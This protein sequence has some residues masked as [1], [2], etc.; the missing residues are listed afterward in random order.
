MTKSTDPDRR[1][2]GSSYEDELAQ[3]FPAV[4]READ[5]L[6]EGRGRLQKTYDRLASRLDQAGI[7]YSLVGGYALI[8]HGV[9][10]FT[11]DIDLLVR[12][13]S[14]RLLTEELV[15]RGYARIP[16]VERSIRDSETGVRIDFVIAGQ[17]PGDGKPKPIVFPDPAS[18][19]V[20]EDGVRVV[21]LT[22]LIE[23][24]LASGM[25]GAGRLQ[26]LADVQRLAEVHHLGEDFAQRL[27]PYVRKKF[28]EIR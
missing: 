6:Y 26:D 28:L 10:R 23:L 14:L 11:E 25:T 3:S 13:K 16:D 12:P 27:N 2:S 21:D 24:K 7:A 22:T 18:F 19:G 4:L 8:L 5:A 9:R 15:G 1:N 17:F 20:S